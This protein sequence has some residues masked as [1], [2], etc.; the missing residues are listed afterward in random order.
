MKSL[1]AAPLLLIALAGPAL[2]Q[3]PSTEPKAVKTIPI[4][5]DGSQ[6][7]AAAPQT[8]AD[9]AKAMQQ[10]E[11]TAIQ[12]DLAWVGAYNG[13]VNGEVSERMINAIKTFQKDQNAK[14]TGV[15]N[16]QER[17]QL[18]AAAKKL[19][20]GV[21][22]KVALDPINGIRLG[23]P[24][25][26]VPQM[27]SMANTSGSKWSSAQ[28]QIQ[29]E[30]WRLRD[31]NQTIAAVAEQQKK[32]PA[33]RKVDYSVVR[34]D[35]F[36]LSG[37]QGLKKFYVRGQIKDNEVRGMTILYDQATE[38]TM[39]PVVIAMSSAFTP[40][41]ASAVQAAAP[42]PRK[43][44]EY[45][46]GIV[47]SA[48]GAIITDRQAVDGCQFIVVPGHGNAERVAED[49]TRDLALLRIYGARELKPIAIGGAAKSS[50][51]LTGIADP[52]SQGGGA[53]ASSTNATLTATSLSP[54]PGIG[55][56]GA[57]AVDA[58]GVFAGMTL[59]KPVVVAG[60]QPPQTANEAAIV[61]ADQVLGFLKAHDVTP[62]TGQ[63][64]DAKAA[65]LR[66]VCVRK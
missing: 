52:H 48:D 23:V 34:P 19:Q 27:S 32:E 11:R 58:D 28:G 12:S 4:R 53:A 15:L 44:V 57:A 35:F 62:A 46:T 33:G 2:A 10:A 38:G 56:T 9:T 64:A 24:T 39:A 40:F 13:A 47:V 6:G 18:A 5:P 55:F 26:L 37:L 49:K 66:V 59:L 30:T 29:I 61:P 54:A 17:Q 43:K 42:P 60:T 7:K 63:K 65:V 50:V 16:P 25:K 36:V 45:A 51:V 14:Q 20:N 1:A 21:G 41:P 31:T 8:P 3:T 22:W